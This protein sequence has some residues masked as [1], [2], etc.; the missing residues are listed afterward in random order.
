MIRGAV[1]E[2]VFHDPRW[3]QM[4]TQVQHLADAQPEEERRRAA[5]HADSKT[6]LFGKGPK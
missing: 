4:S 6:E 5:A 3:I 1:I 2:D